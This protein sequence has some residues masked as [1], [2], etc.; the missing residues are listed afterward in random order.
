MYV[1]VMFYLYSYKLHQ[2]TR[3]Q[4]RKVNSTQ[5]VSTLILAHDQLKRLKFAF[6]EA[7]LLPS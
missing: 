3:I 2:Y 7:P 1:C 6:V 5:M 4:S